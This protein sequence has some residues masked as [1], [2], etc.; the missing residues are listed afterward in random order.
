MSENAIAAFLTKKYSWSHRHR[1]LYYTITFFYTI[2][3]CTEKLQ[4]TIQNIIQINALETLCLCINNKTVV[5][6]NIYSSIKHL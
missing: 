2:R 5:F 1:S 3:K 6:R 4:Q